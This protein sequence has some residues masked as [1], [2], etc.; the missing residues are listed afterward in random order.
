MR[1]MIASLPALRLPFA[2]L[3][4]LSVLMACG[5][6]GPG[7]EEE[8][9]VVEP[10]DVDGDAD[11]EEDAED[12]EEDIDV[13]EEVDTDPGSVDCSS[14]RTCESLGSVCD[15][16]VVVS[17]VQDEDGCFVL[18]EE[19]CSGVTRQVCVDGERFSRTN[20]CTQDEEGARCTPTDSPAP[21]DEGESCIDG[22]EDRDARCFDLCQ[23][24]TL[25]DDDAPEAR[26]DG[27]LF[28]RCTH[29]SNGC[30]VRSLTN[31]RN[32]NPAS[33][34]CDD[35]TAIRQVPTCVL[36]EDDAPGCGL[37]ERTET[38]EAPTFCEE[39]AQSAVC[40]DPCAGLTLCDAE[41]ET[42]P[43]C[44]GDGVSSCV[45]NDDGCQVVTTTSC[46]SPTFAC[47]GD[48]GEAA[49]FDPCEGLTLCDETEPDSVC[50]DDDTLVTCTEDAA[51]CRV[52]ETLT[53]EGGET[54]LVGSAGASVCIDP[55]AG[56]TLCDEGDPDVRCEDNRSVT[57]TLDEFG[58]RLET[59]ENCGANGENCV[60]LA[61]DGDD[62]EQAVCTSPCP[63]AAPL[64]CGIEETFT[65]ADV[66]ADQPES[67]APCGT[68][69]DTNARGLVVLDLPGAINGRVTLSVRAA[70]GTEDPEDMRLEVVGVRHEPGAF[71]CEELNT[72]S[73]DRC[74]DV[75]VQVNTVTGAH[76]MTFPASTTDRFY[77]FVTAAE[78][79]DALPESLTIVADCFAAVCGNGLVEP[80]EECDDDN[81]EAGDGCSPTCRVEEGW[82]C[83][84]SPSVCTE[85]TE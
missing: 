5:S 65:V 81:T 74:L 23:G 45:L 36:D 66:S 72:V 34:T 84:G 53:C 85:V 39:T 31:C 8:P 18:E 3:L 9:D 43:R 62:P 41:D 46:E 1:Q 50:E 55:C 73:P 48:P 25:C 17:C 64:I 22:L 14:R 60:T 76:S 7:P 35:E 21:C 57:C 32:A 19:F 13:T 27:E 37:E 16:A 6:D 2:A 28:I 71:F 51:G 33:G 77:L 29:D 52:R 82:T 44:D 67:L 79:G 56:Q 26:C 10:E 63:Q 69:G 15:G 30:Y 49:C 24:L 38:C 75:P 20:R 12:V 80:G 42:F 61:A 4:C 59:T 47:G 11:A 78:E 70:D 40:T 58:C 68:V 54:C 83:T